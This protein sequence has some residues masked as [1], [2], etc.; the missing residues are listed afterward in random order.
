MNYVTVEVNPDDDQPEQFHFNNFAEFTV[1]V[2][3]DRINPLLDV[4]FDGRHIVDGEYVSSNPEILFRLKDENKYLAL[5][6]SS[7]FLIYMIYPNDPL[8]PVQLTN[9]QADVTYIPANPNN[10]DR[11]NEAR[12]IYKPTLTDGTYEI[13]AQGIDRSKNDAGKYD[14]RIRFK[15]DSKPSITNVLNYPNPFSTSTQFV[16]TITGA[17]VPDQLIIQIFSASGRVVK[18]I[19]K[20]ELGNLHIGTNVTNYKWDGTDNFGDRLANGVYFYRVM[21]KNLDG[22]TTEIK[23]STIDKYFKKGYGKLYIIR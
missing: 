5:N 15:V 20:E 17:T 14:Y 4:T 21:T 6:D 11:K 3:R 23:E 10:L 9:A 1:F 8:N 12:L 22:T 7:E 19:T 13:R 16:F 18:E 2:E